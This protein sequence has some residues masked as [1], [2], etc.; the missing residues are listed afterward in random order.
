[1]TDLAERDL[2]KLFLKIA[3]I[4]RTVRDIILG[5]N[6]ITCLD[7]LLKNRGKWS[8]WGI[9]DFQ[10][11]T[12]KDEYI[13]FKAIDAEYDWI[14]DKNENTFKELF[15]QKSGVSLE[16]IVEDDDNID[17]LETEDLDFNENNESI[18]ESMRMKMEFLKF[19]IYY[20]VM[21][22]KQKFLFSKRLL[23]LQDTF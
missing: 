2:L 6:K 14:E 16:S 22:K 20:R 18:P 4:N 9:T 17:Q 19:K 8:E 5:T 21:L 7:D 1:M 23:L 11:Q 13:K 15:E 12:L 3:K 10:E